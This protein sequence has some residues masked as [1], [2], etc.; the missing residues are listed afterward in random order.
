MSLFETCVAAV[1]A[2][3]LKLS[4]F[5]ILYVGGCCRRPLDVII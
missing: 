5:E 2:A 3:V 1:A 4:S